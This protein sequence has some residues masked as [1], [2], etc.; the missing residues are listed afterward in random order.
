MQR[1]RAVKRLRIQLLG[2]VKAADRTGTVIFIVAIAIRQVFDER[3][4][5]LAF[6]RRDH[7]PHIDAEVADGVVH[8]AAERVFS[9]LAE[10]AALRAERRNGACENTSASAG[11]L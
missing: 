1:I 8:H 9:D 2:A 4:P 3:K 5:D 10:K 11:Y 6:V 7:V